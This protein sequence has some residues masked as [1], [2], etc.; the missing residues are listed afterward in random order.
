MLKWN[1]DVDASHIEATGA[2]LDAMVARLPEVTEYRHGADLGLAD[3][4]YDYAIVAEFAS[5]DDYAIYRDDPEHQRVLADY[6]RDHVRARAAVQYDA[7]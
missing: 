5:V 6:I 2:A 3:G 4:N 1:D 7:G